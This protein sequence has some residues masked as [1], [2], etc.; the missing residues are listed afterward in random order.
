MEVSEHGPLDAPP[1]LLLHGLLIDRTMWQPVVETLGHSFRLLIPDLP[2]HG[3]ARNRRWNSMSRVVDDL[4]DLVDSRVPDARVGVVGLSL[5]GY[6]ALELARA[7]PDRIAGVVASGVNAVPLPFW[8]PPRLLGPVLAPFIVTRPML[9][10]NA[11][12]LRIPA[13]L[14]P[15][16]RSAARRTHPR[17]FARIN[18]ELT[19]YRPPVDNAFVRPVL[20]LC[21]GDEPPSIRRSAPLLAAA[22]ARGEHRTVPG[23][24]HGWIIERPALFTETVSNF[25]TPLFP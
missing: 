2:G 11:R 8:S 4:T 15:W 19:G 18:R 5:G 17:A 12:V 24:G 23:V 3:T 20:V 21:G 16:Y 1:L 10:A 9:S 6:L 14:H 22:F 13:D 7:A 25:I